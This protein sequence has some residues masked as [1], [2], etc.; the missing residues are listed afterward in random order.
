MVLLFSLYSSLSI[1]LAAITLHHHLNFVASSPLFRVLFV[2]SRWP[3][4][5]DASHN[6]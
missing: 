5:K 3:E 2:R 6:L 4:K 1:I